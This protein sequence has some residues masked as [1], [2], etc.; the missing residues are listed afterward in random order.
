MTYLK[1]VVPCCVLLLLLA[2]PLH[3]AE[4]S[5]NTIAD[6]FG[7]NLNS[8]SLREAL[9]AAQLNAA[10]G[11]CIAGTA[12]ET[13]RV[14][15]AV[16]GT[17]TLIRQAVGRPDD[18][19]IGDI[20]VT[21]GGG[22]NIRGNGTEKTII[23]GNGSTRIFHFDRVRVTLSNVTLQN[24]R[25][26]IVL[27][28]A[29]QQDIESHGAAVLAN[30]ADGDLALEN[31]VLRNN[32]SARDGGAIALVASQLTVRRSSFRDNQSGNDGGAIFLSG[33][34]T[35]RIEQSAFIHNVAAALGGAIRT[36]LGGIPLQ[37]NRTTFAQNQ[38]QKG[39]AV[40]IG[41]AGATLTNLTFFA[42][43]SD[44][45]AALS[46]AQTDVTVTNGI[47]AEGQGFCTSVNF[48]ENCANDVHVKSGGHNY[49]SSRLVVDFSQPPR[50][51]DLSLSNGD[52]VQ[53]L[54][55]RPFV[56]D[57]IAGNPRV[58]AQ[59]T[60]PT[61][62]AGKAEVCAPL[63]SDQLTLPYRGVCDIGAVE[64][65]CGDGILQASDAE[66]CD[67]SNLAS[68]DGCSDQCIAEANPPS[69]GNAKKEGSEN[70][71][72]GNVL[73]GDGCSSECQPESLPQS[74]G[75]GTKENSEECDDG[76][77]RS[78]DGCSDR[79]TAEPGNEPCSMGN[80][81]EV[82]C[83]DSRLDVEAGE[84]CDDGNES[85]GDGCS[86]NC[87]IEQTVAATPPSPTSS[88][89]LRPSR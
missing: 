14:S 78:G 84:F 46:V 20:D 80:I 43:I 85:N 34:G 74:C 59:T 27:N 61:I 17:F 86:R 51:C 15:F 87:L 52:L 49:F 45:G 1:K 58:P 82:C 88:C 12:N 42:N 68:G 13:D 89:S 31:C 38:A 69:C 33:A 37:L 54:N 36:N 44:C 3:A 62:N 48:G 25:T 30:G 23:D 5:V 6:E 39:G 67:D 24:G 22:L 40:H 56:D 16:D 4:I 11:G 10:F 65:A 7:E 75:N 18:V 50:N 19:S 32:T 29:G 76:N 71:D 70:C 26:M 77:T 35:A 83:G 8:C 79:C 60:S 57:P 41:S 21:G 2:I 28:Q 72:D 64:V 47:F 63:G 81:N 53:G 73:N 55:L 66:E 9:Q